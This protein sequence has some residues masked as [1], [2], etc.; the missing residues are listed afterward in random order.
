MND[1]VTIIIS[2]YKRPELLNRSLRSALNQTYSNIEVIV[3]DDNE[4]NSPAR[5]ETEELIK[6]TYG[7]YDNLRYVQMPKNSGA[8]AARNYGVEVSQG[9]YVAFLDDDDEFLPDKT[10]RQMEVFEADKEEKLSVV[11]CYLEVVDGNGKQLQISKDNYKGDVFFTQMCDT[12]CCTLQALVRKTIFMKSGGFE[13][14]HSCQ[15]HWMLAKLFSV[16]PYYDYVP[17]IL[18]RAYHHEGVRI[19][20]NST[21][22]LGVVELYKNCMTLL[23]R[24]TPQQAAVI[25]RKRNDHVITAYLHEGMKKEAFY[26]WKQGVKMRKFIGLKDIYQFF[27]IFIGEKNNGKLINFL[28]RIKHKIVK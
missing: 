8:C 23:D 16:N 9:K 22:P 18:C 10:L 27:V 12:V 14:M 6:T 25:I 21:R 24:F 15:E 11:G 4:P 28:S 7:H 13:T 3:V 5:K 17:E 19:S 20:T 26:Y 2:T 1:L